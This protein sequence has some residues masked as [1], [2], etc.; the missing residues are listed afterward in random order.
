MSLAHMTISEQ[1]LGKLC[2]VARRGN[3]SGEI[4]N[5]YRTSKK[6]LFTAY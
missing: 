2:A 6:R 4:F 5:V 1:S 3:L